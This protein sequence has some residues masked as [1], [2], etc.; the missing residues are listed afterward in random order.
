LSAG[1]ASR[2]LAK[3]PRALKAPK[4]TPR[5]NSKQARRVPL[6]KPPLRLVQAFDAIERAAGGREA[7][8]DR[9]T[10]GA[11]TVEQQYV[12][13]L[14]ADPRNDS[15]SLA[16]IADMA[17]LPV[18]KLWQFIKDAGVA[19]A[20]MEAQEEIVQHAAPLARDV[21]IRTLPRWVRCQECRGRGDLELLVDGKR[22]V[23]TCEECAG[24]GQVVKDPTI[25]YQKL[26]LEL[27]KIRERGN[28]GVSVGVGVQVNNGAPGMTSAGFRSVTDRLLYGEEAGGEAVDV[29]DAEIVDEEEEA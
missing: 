5:P 6:A 16:T 1:A 20:I 27:L 17:R 4:R 18:G 24:K 26:G 8:V 13:G 23:R 2:A 12:V 15:K 22:E 3:V 7:L 10:H 11:L 9:L 29:V 19:R 21:M 28:A 25:E 14:M